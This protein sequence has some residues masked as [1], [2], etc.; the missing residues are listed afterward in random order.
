MAKETKKKLIWTINN[1]ILQYKGIHPKNVHKISKICA[2]VSHELHIPKVIVY[3]F[4]EAPLV[5]EVTQTDGEL[6]NK[7]FFTFIFRNFLVQTLQYFLKK[8]DLFLSMKTWQNCPQ[9]LLIIDPF[10]FSSNLNFCS[11]EI[12]HRWT[13]LFATEE[14]LC[15]ITVGSRQGSLAKPLYCCS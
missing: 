8:K 5:R 13:F 7:F 11:I 3:K 12:A 4:W 9:K 15:S 2:I 6:N 1:A 10:F 14:I